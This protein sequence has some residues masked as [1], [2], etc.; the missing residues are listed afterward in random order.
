[1]AHTLVLCPSGENL[2]RRSPRR[3]S[4][5]VF[6][7]S[8]SFYG[9]SASARP[10]SRTKS[11]TAVT[12]RSPAKLSAA[13]EGQD[14]DDACSPPRFS[15]SL[16]KRFALHSLLT[17]VC[18]NDS[19]KGNKTGT[20][21]NPTKTA[22]RSS[23]RLLKKRSF[24]CIG[25]S[26]ATPLETSSS[27]LRTCKPDE[28]QVSSSRKETFPDANCTPKKA[29]LV[30]PVR[31][32]PRLNKEQHLQQMPLEEKNL[33]DKDHLNENISV[34]ITPKS[35]KKDSSKRSRRSLPKLGN[36][37]QL[38]QIPENEMVEENCQPD[39]KTSL[40]TTP[41]SAKRISSEGC[42]ETPS[43]R[44]RNRQHLQ[45]TPSKEFVEE[46]CQP[47]VKTSLITTPKSAKRIPSEGCRETPSPRL[48][49]RKQLQ[50]TPSKEFVEDNCQP[51]LKTSLITT[52][53]S[54]KRIPCGGSGGT[55]SP[56]LR[57]RQQLQQT[58]K[59]ES[60]NKKGEL[61]ANEKT[62]RTATP[63][64]SG[65]TPSKGTRGP[66]AF[67]VSSLRT[68]ESTK[69]NA[70]QELS[71]LS[72]RES[73]ED[74]GVEDCVVLL[75]PVKGQL[76]SPKGKP[77][78]GLSWP[79]ECVNTSPLE[80]A[81]A[82]CVQ[83]GNSHGIHHVELHGTVGKTQDPN[84]HRGFSP[85]KI[86]SVQEVGL[87]EKQI[88]S[89]PELKNA[90]GSQALFQES[91]SSGH[92]SEAKDLSVVLSDLLKYP[93]DAS[94]CGSPA[95]STPPLKRTKRRRGSISGSPVEAKRLSPLNQILKQRKRKRDDVNKRT[96]EYKSVGFSESPLRNIKCVIQPSRHKKS[97]QTKTARKTKV[98][99]STTSSDENDWISE[100]EK[101]LDDKVAS[102]REKKPSC[103][104]DVD[105]TS[106][107]TPPKKKR[108]VN[109]AVVFGSTR[110][111]GS[112]SAGA[113]K[114]GPTSLSK[115]KLSFQGGDISQSSPVHKRLK[116]T[117]LSKTPISA[118]SLKILQESPILLGEL[119]DPQL[120]NC[121][122]TRT[123]GSGDSP[124]TTERGNREKQHKCQEFRNA[125][126]SSNFSIEE[127]GGFDRSAE[128]TGH[129]INLRKRLK[130]ETS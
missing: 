18:S 4:S 25:F 8:R 54:A 63:A 125:S 126:D 76:L 115:S 108:R 99:I 33:E 70:T 16:K 47:D 67:Q 128:Q 119:S 122:L 7:R 94:V 77:E 127:L 80:T 3:S 59:K 86:S 55:S 68:H 129:R 101:E 48:R 74:F 40:I 5:S 130:L 73:L 97:P 60:V 81:N 66:L 112:S 95:S 9:R 121:S 87:D 113:T 61:D 12:S 64:S 28:L 26:T 32:S 42:R 82:Y 98:A 13:N 39:V 15:P 36:K 37:Q 104:Y 45:K 29:L 103:A 11:F 109:K 30:S 84:V 2:P 21:L 57:N 120:S 71:S 96:P 62:S 44:L 91:R 102:S 35:S 85:K 41:K 19:Q 114:T 92:L 24:S 51:G 17:S 58:P 38:Q 72:K 90:F 107:T 105:V 106:R 65:M 22:V 79:S 93:K 111:R 110:I 20:T 53:K 46:K 50:K 14:S 100:I 89:S 1:M 123:Q 27:P 117:Q 43:P 34:I 83:G 75:T 88:C 49:D 10:L 52:P 118:N 23:P 124:L 69:K 6:Q 78:S 56:R 116:N 31:C